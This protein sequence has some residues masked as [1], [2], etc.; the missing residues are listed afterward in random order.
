M[1]INQKLKD[2]LEEKY[3]EYSKPAY[4]LNTDPIQVPHQFSKKEDIEISAFLS[5]TI[6]WGQRKTIIDNAK[7]LMLWMDNSPHQFILNANGKELKPFENFVHRTFN[8]TDCLTFIAALKNIYTHHQ[9]LEQVFCLPADSFAQ[10][11]AQFKTLFFEIDHLPRT[12]KHLADPSKGSSAKRI[13]MFLRWMVRPANKGS[14]FGIWTKLSPADLHLPLDVHSGRIARN[15]GLLSRAQDD[16]KAVLE[17]T[18]AMQEYDPS[19]P[20]KYDYALFG[21]GAFEKY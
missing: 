11:I 19:D 16:W 7:K 21:L 14:D 15:L 17:L 13:C 10:R 3:L 9:G 20:C 8:G 1:P 6:A 18:K 2:F 12:H 4:F 5:A